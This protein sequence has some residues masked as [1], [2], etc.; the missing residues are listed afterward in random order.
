MKRLSILILAILMVLGLSSG[1]ALADT[2]QQAIKNSDGDAVTILVNE[3]PVD[4]NVEPVMTDG[5]LMVPFRAIGEVMGAKVDWDEKTETASLALNDTE[6][7]LT[8]GELSGMVNGSPVDLDA[9]AKLVNGHVLI[10]LRFV[11]EALGAQVEWNAENKQVQIKTPAKESEIKNFTQ[12][13]WVDA[14]KE[15]KLRTGI[16]MKYIEMGSPENKTIV[17]I[18]GVTDTS[19]S[20][21]LAAPY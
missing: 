3:K 7:N 2:T 16:K 1:F 6:V 18:H 14:K 21:S 13:N 20:W 15:I 9:A 10:P 19:R 11:N 12:K 8:L 4:L 5:R 17:L